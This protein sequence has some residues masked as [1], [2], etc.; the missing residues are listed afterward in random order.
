MEDYDYAD[1]AP[2]HVDRE[3]IKTLILEQGIT[4]IGSLAFANCS[5]LTSVNIPEGINNLQKPMQTRRHK[6]RT[7]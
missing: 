6:N 4:S 3:G 5:S 1:S 7:K 2:W